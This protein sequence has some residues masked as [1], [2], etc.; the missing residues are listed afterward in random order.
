[1]ARRNLAK[2]LASKE[3][4][5]VSGTWKL[6]TNASPEALLFLAVT[7]RQAPVQ[8]KIK[9]FF[10]QVA[11]G[12]REA[13]VPG[14]GGA[15]DHAA[16][17]GVSEDCGR[18]LPDVAGWKA[19]LAHRHCEV[20]EA[21]CSTAASTASSTPRTCTESCSSS[22]RARSGRRRAAWQ[23]GSEREEGESCGG[24]SSSPA[25]GSASSRGETDVKAKA[26][27]K[28]KPTKADA[29]PSKPAPKPAKKAA[30]KPAPKPAKKKK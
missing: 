14:D 12:A 19:A 15:A 10:G 5:T 4:N 26:P 11:A 9:N 17:A 13:A 25:S 3:A 23:A 28:T 24:S 21:V 7:G 30:P 29:K 18:G 6:L 27:E 16:A 2:R 8:E 22:S 20:P 1:M